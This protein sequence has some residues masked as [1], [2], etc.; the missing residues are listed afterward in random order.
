MDVVSI[1]GVLDCEQLRGQ[2]N[3]SLAGYLIPELLDT[4]E[5]FV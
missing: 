1:E 3:L 4:L 5:R 2:S